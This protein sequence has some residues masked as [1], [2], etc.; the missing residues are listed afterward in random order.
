VRSRSRPPGTP[1]VPV[2]LSEIGIGYDGS[3]E[4]EHALAFARAIAAALGAHGALRAARAPPRGGQSR[5]LRQGDFLGSPN[6][7]KQLSAHR[8]HGRTLLDTLL[9]STHELLD[10]EYETELLGGPPARAIADVARARD[11]DEIV[12]GAHGHGRVRALLGSV[13]HELLHIADR[14]VVVIPAAA[15]AQRKSQT[16]RESAA[17]G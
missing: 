17:R 6:F 5:R 1:G 11:A 4:S 7:D 3:P 14:P 15:A 9:V 10:V 2:V 8:D 12:V 13:S 16:Q